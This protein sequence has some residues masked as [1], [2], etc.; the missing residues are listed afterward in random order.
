MKRNIAIISTLKPVDDIRGFWKIG[1]SIAKTNKYDVNIIGNSTKFKSHIPNITFHEFEISRQSLLKRLQLP[2]RVLRLLFHIRPQIVI[3]TS[4]EL[5][6]ISIF[7]K[8]ISKGKLIYDIQ[9]NYFKNF[10]FLQLGIKKYLAY[11]IRFK[12]IILSSFIDGYFLAEKCYVD[13]INFPNNY[14]IL[15]NKAIKIDKKNRIKQP[16]SY[17][18]SGTISTYA[19][20]KN[21]INLFQYILLEEPES[22]LTIIGQVHDPILY[23]WLNDL[24]LMERRIRLLIDQKPIPYPKIFEAIQ[25]HDIGIVSYVENEVNKN[26]VP[27][28]MYE[29]LHFGMTILSQKDASWTKKFKSNDKV[30]AIDFN[31][32]KEEKSLIV[33]I[34]KAKASEIKSTNSLLWN[35]QESQLVDYLNTFN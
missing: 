17:L 28:K 7:Y 19:G 9:E 8:V 11:Y 18:F 6:M 13:E 12:E 16:N 30:V 5:L 3:I 15:E 22:T 2:F 29:Y 10:F 34:E 14:L 27:T 24:Q 21:A 32:I 35:S 4:H 20:I 33:R 31:A 25:T 1:Q 23:K 26:K